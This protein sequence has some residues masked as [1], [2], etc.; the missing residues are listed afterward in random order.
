ME[1]AIRTEIEDLLGA[2]V[3]GVLARGGGY[4]TA[5]CW[6]IDL[7]DGR[8]LFA[9]VAVDE[10]GE[11]GN[12]TEAIVLGAS[13]SMHRPGLVARTVEGRMLVTEDLPDA[14][15]QPTTGGLDTLWEAVAAIGAQRGPPSLRQG[16]QGAG[17]D[18]W[19]VVLADDRFAD[20]VDVDA[21]WLSRHGTVISAA[22]RRADTS[23]DRLVHSDLGPGNWCRDRRG[24]WMFVDWASAY[25]GN[26]LVDDAMVAVRLTRLRGEP[27]CSRRLAAN[28][29]IAA[30]ISGGFAGELLDVDWLAAPP[31]ARAD[32]VADIR[33]GLVLVAHLLEIES[34]WP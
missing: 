9:K 25:R 8:R 31:A 32:R 14:D 29:Q 1:A 6:T 23:G 24:R 15:W 4:T 11:V 18:P 12:R 26:P 10:D 22:A 33:A 5:R 19:E 17:R 27:C 16:Y 2:R 3:D 20:A 30:F 28:P 13:R 34:P 7:A 21:G